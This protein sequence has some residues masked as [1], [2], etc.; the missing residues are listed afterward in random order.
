MSGI[1]NLGEDPRMHSI[2]ELPSAYHQVRR[3]AG[4]QRELCNHI[5]AIEGLTLPRTPA[6]H[7]FH[8]ADV[9]RN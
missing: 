8:F 4:L 6:E 1:D 7:P 3:G 5:V 9:Y 2:L